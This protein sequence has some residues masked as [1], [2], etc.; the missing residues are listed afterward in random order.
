M[1]PAQHRLD[2]RQ[3]LARVERLGHV[4]VGAELEPDHPVGLLG[5]RG[6]H[7]DRQVALRA[8]LPAQGEAVLAR[9]HDVEHDQVDPAG[10]E[11]AP[12]RRGT[13]GDAD[14]VVVPGQIVGQ[15]VADL[16]MIVDD[17]EVGGFAHAAM[18]CRGLGALCAVPGMAQRGFVTDCRRAAPSPHP[19][20]IG[21]VAAQSG[22][23]CGSSA[24]VTND[25]VDHATD[26]Q[27]ILLAARARRC[28]LLAAGAAMADG[29]WGGPAGHGGPRRH[30][31]DRDLRHQQATARSPRPRSTP[32][33]RTSLT[34]FDTDGNGELSLEEYQA[35]WLDAMRPSDGPPVPG[36][37]SPTAMPASPSWSSRSATRTWSATSTAT[38]T[39]SSPST[40][41]GRR[42]GPRHGPGPGPGPDEGPERGPGRARG[43]TSRT[44]D[45]S[46]RRGGGVSLPPCDTCA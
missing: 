8:Q 20:Q 16:A 44:E 1:G 29:G 21:C 33:A 36:Q 43:R 11:H 10:L 12:R 5:H 6:Q 31:P 15:R 13:V 25:E 30:A 39:A 42:H 17:Q 34:K 38:A 28:R 45:C 22:Q 32:R 14:P 23:I 19:R 40:S 2:P 37:R 35:L 7:D 4:V 3:Q 26:T 46:T 18:S 41:C 9:H 24:A 27:D